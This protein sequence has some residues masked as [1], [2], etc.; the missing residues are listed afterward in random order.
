MLT[1]SLGSY[2]LQ[3]HGWAGHLTLSEFL[4]VKWHSTLTVSLQGCGEVR[5]EVGDS[6]CALEGPGDVA[7]VTGTE[8]R[9]S[10]LLTGPS[11]K[12]CSSDCLGRSS[13]LEG[14]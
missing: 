8:E 3:N 2:F 1:P 10:Q 11:P 14:G 12:G 6:A 7:I 5:E 13:L 4:R 9:H